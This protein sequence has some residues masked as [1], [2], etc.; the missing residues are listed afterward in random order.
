M[1]IC[2]FQGFGGSEVRE[3]SR[4]G[5]LRSGCVAA[6][7]IIQHHW[8]GKSL[9]DLKDMKNALAV[10]FLI[11]GLLVTLWSWAYVVPVPGLPAPALSGMGSGLIVLIIP[12]IL[13]WL[14]L[15]AAFV[16]LLWS[17]RLNSWAPYGVVRVILVVVGITM[18]EICMASVFI[19]CVDEAVAPHLHL[20]FKALMILFPVGVMAGGLLGSRALF[21]V[22]AVGAL[23]AAT[24]P[25]PKYTPPPP[26]PNSVEYLL[27]RVDS[28]P[29]LKDV[30]A[31]LETHPRWVK[32]A[33]R[34]LD[35]GFGLNAAVL[36]SLKPGALDQGVQERCW[37]EAMSSFARAK[38]VR[39]WRENWMPGEIR[40]IAV[41][42]NG[43]ASIAGPV[44]DR[45][46]ADFVAV[47]DLVN[48]YRNE[49]PERRYPELPDLR[50]V[51]WMTG[52]K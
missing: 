26:D 50:A 27:H 32:D 10:V 42:V 13:R 33:S 46:R 25:I 38:Q 30:L 31:R 36:L 3:E 48:F 34:S 2:R 22:G 14:A 35:G 11:A 19:R 17:G 12:A 9:T 43:L 7:I 29:D 23:V 49:T 41:I 24:W 6:M 44:R 1:S 21:A 20:L 15:A 16:F 18:L 5:S 51:D 4:L 45:H 52:S 47:R 40:N 28:E 8:G 37:K 39:V